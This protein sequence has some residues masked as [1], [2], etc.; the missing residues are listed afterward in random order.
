MNYP[1]PCVNKTAPFALP[2]N[3]RKLLADVCPSLAN[4]KSN[5]AN[6]AFI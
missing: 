6:A 3:K 2:D 5:D 1:K 4:S